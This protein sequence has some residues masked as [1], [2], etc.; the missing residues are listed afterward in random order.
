[1]FLPPFNWFKMLSFTLSFINS[2]FLW[3]L[4]CNSKWHFSLYLWFS[5]LVCPKKCEKRACTDEGECCHPQCLGSCTEPDNDKACAACQHY[6]HEDRCV[7]ACPPGTYKF[8][9]WR[10]I[11]MDMCARVHLPSE[12]DFVIHNGECM[13]ECPPGFTR[14]ET[15]RYAVRSGCRVASLNASVKSVSLGFC[16]IIK[17]KLLKIIIKQNI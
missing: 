13:P 7:E 12:V 6:F 4:L 1:M 3:V 11:T 10:C 14:N 15:Q 2:L 16:S 9:G 8:E 17:L 5:L